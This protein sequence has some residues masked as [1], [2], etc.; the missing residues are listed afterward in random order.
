MAS[1]G[2]DAREERRRRRSVFRKEQERNLEEQGVLMSDEESQE[3]EVPAAAEAFEHGLLQLDENEDFSLELTESEEGDTE[4]ETEIKKSDVFLERTKQLEEENLK[5]QERLKELERREQMT[6]QR[7]IELDERRKAFEKRMK[8]YEEQERRGMKKKIYEEM[9]EKN[10]KMLTQLEDD[11]K[12]KQMKAL[13]REKE[14]EEKEKYLKMEEDRWAAE[15]TEIEKHF[16]EKMKEVLQKEYMMTRTDMN[17]STNEKESCEQINML[18][19]IKPNEAPKVYDS[20]ELTQKDL[21]IKVD[22]KKE[23]E[24]RV[25]EMSK[26]KTIVRQKEPE[27]VRMKPYIGTFSG[28]EPKPKHESSFED[29]KLEVESLIAAEIY[30]NIDIA[31]AIRKALKGQ[32]KKVLLTMGPSAKPQ[33]M[34][35]RIESVFGNVASG[36]AVLQEFYTAQQGVDESVADWGL[37]LE[38]IL[39][40]AIDKG[41]VKEDS[42]NEMLRSKFWR[43]LYDQ[44]L[45]NA[46]KIYH[47]T[48]K[49]F[50]EL[51][52]KVRAEEYEMKTG[53]AAASRNKD[54]RQKEDKQFKARHQPIITES[55]EQV[56]ILKNLM[57][58]LTV[59][60]KDIQQ[61]KQNRGRRW[62]GGRGGRRQTYNNDQN[63]GTQETKE[64][65]TEKQGKDETKPKS[66]NQ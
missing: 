12:K 35:K 48:I 21:A 41:H 51:R 54:M 43:S 5:F 24:E 45:K 14:I 4:E 66:L 44:A 37:R 40:K 36:E 56:N 64:K 47:E 50:E 39:Q 17:V 29:F 46:T 20:K 58:K 27:Q 57:E 28:S 55:D 11:L 32:A 23:L 30:S 6:A 3:G 53:T 62:R 19:I 42:K 59:M 15:E 65:N 25:S 13:E 16:K 26:E 49:S 18:K 7:G 9:Y 1:G 61:M 8:D 63:K 33:D 22:D 60:E 38:E 10:A 52:R 31:Q 2:Y 34:V